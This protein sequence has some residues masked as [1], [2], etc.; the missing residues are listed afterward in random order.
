MLQGSLESALLIRFR[1]LVIGLT[2]AGKTTILQR[3]CNTTANPEVYKIDEDGGRT[4]IDLHPSSERGEHEISDEIEFPNHKGYV[5]HDSRGLECGSEAEQQ[6]IQKFIHDKSQGV[7]LEDRLHAI[8]YC[9][10]M[11]G[12]RYFSAAEPCGRILGDMKIPTIAVFTKCEFF[13][14]N[15]R[16]DLEDD[17][18]KQYTSAELDHAAPLKCREIFAKC[19]ALVSNNI[20]YLKEMHLLGASC[21]NLVEAT[22]D[23]LDPPTVAIMLLAVQRDNIE[24]GVWYA[25]RLAGRLDIW[26]NKPVS[27][28]LKQNWIPI[29]LR[30]NLVM[31]PHLWMEMAEDVSL[32]FSSVIGGTFMI[33]GI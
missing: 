13:E 16:L 14:S 7:R 31:F 20:V 23:A 18:T 29:M 15:V 4:Q 28:G 30:Y 17:E 6:I 21:H 27:Q 22:M 19:A 25:L 3:L 5:F 9:I 2:C 24:H 8:W 12:N 33:I 10:P 26:A 32:Q 1:V 11:D